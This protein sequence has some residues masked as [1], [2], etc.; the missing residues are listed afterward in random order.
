MPYVTLKLGEPQGIVMRLHYLVE[1]SGPPVIFVHGLGGFA[2]SWRRN[3]SALGRHF[4][5]YAVDLPGCG[6]S[7]KPNVPYRLPFFVR[8]LGSFTEAL[9]LEKP[10]I[11]GHSLG[12]AMVVAYAVAHPWSVGRLALV[13]PVVPGFGYRPSWLYRLAVI[14]LLGELGAACASRNIVRRSIARCFQQPDPD[15]VDFLVD[16]GYELRRSA[17]GRSAYLSTLREF[18]KDFRLSGSFYHDH[19]AALDLPILLIHGQ[20]DRVARLWQSEAIIKRLRKGRLEVFEDCGHFPHIEQSERH[21]RCVIEFL[22]VKPA[23]I[24]S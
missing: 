22:S 17:A 6:Q 8:V 16:H 12:G 7:D 21:N 2:E 14:P 11:V 5:I 10:S 3:L 24:R 1:G 18:R 20:E 19:V 4:T 9:Q 23:S 15:E 13:A